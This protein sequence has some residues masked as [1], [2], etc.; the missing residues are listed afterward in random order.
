MPA[1]IAIVAGLLTSLSPLAPAA[2]PT[3]FPHSWV[4]EW[5]GPGGS[6]PAE[7]DALRFEMRLRIAPT[8]DPDRFTWTI[9]YITT[10]RAD[11]RPYE[12]VVVDAE[13]GLYEVDEKNSIVLPARWIDG[14]LY[15]RFDLG[16]TALVAGYRVEDIGTERERMVV[17]IVTTDG[18]DAPTTGGE[19]GV[20]T[21]SVPPVK[22]V[23]RAVMTRN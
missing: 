2:A 12:L 15:S 18:A 8:D 9:A 7:G 4:G 20:P 14:G 19:N 22:A 3:P 13:K 10:D 6:T 21:I 17:E 5:R 1:R 11:E 16:E 23:M